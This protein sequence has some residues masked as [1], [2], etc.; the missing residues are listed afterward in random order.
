MTSLLFLLLI[1][2]GSYLLGFRLGTRRGKAE[3]WMDAYFDS[4]AKDRAR[5]HRNG[6][7]K[8]KA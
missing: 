6:Q 4:V 2:L 1:A 5:R 3:G 8:A 7:F